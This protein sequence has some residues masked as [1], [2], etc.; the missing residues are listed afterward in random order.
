MLQGRG[1]S[2][3]Q[4]DGI[5]IQSPATIPIPNKNTVQPTQVKLKELMPKYLRDH[6]LQRS[7]QM[8]NMK[9]GLPLILPGT[10][11][12][13]LPHRHSGCW[14]CFPAP[15]EYCEKDYS[16]VCLSVGPEIFLRDR[17]YVLFRM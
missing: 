13:A 4:I 1:E 5:K 16:C 7:A 6:D 14:R 17:V 3:Q 11:M 15:F 8:V 12:E 2:Q 10:R 9:R